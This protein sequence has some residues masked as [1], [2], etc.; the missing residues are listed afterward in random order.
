M[1]LNTEMKSAKTTFLS[2][3]IL[4]VTHIAWGQSHDVFTQDRV[5]PV[6]MVK[7][8]PNPAT[9]FLSIKFETPQARTVKLTLHNIIGNSLEVESEIIDDFEIRLRVKDLPSG[10]YLLAMKDDSNQRSAFKFLKR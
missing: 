10:Y 9:D 5:D 4:L 3:L 6:K 2:V 8:F 7:L 1:T